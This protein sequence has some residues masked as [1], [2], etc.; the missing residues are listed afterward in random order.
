MSPSY[1]MI[2]GASKSILRRQGRYNGEP[3]PLT[4]EARRL[5][6][7]GGASAAA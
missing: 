2:I 1:Q 5:F 6:G 4:A 3:L 7:L